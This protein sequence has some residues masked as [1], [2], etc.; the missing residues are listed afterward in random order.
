MTDEFTEGFKIFCQWDHHWCADVVDVWWTHRWKI[1]LVMLNLDMS[2][3]SHL[4]PSLSSFSLFYLKHHWW[5]LSLL[6]WCSLC[7]LGGALS[8][9][10]VWF[11][12]TY[13][14]L[15]CICFIFVLLFSIFSPFMCWLS[16]FSSL[17]FNFIIIKKN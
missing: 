11:L 16:F 1:P 6:H 5:S 14:P 2:R 15:L 9:L 3:Q 8:L 4:S 10:Q 13:W 12:F 17:F 7:P